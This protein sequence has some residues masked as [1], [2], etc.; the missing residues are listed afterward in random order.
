MVAVSH[1]PTDDLPVEKVNPFQP[2]DPTFGS[3]SAAPRQVPTRPAT[4]SAVCAF[5]VMVGVS[6]VL[7]Q[8]HVMQIITG[9]QAAD[10]SFLEGVL[11]VIAANLAVIGSV[12]ILV[13]R[14]T[15]RSAAALHKFED[16]RQQ[17]EA[18]AREAAAFVHSEKHSRGRPNRP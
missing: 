4:F 3:A 6:W 16:Q 18:S 10:Q 17:L 9:Q 1:N 12:W 8:H 11:M 13:R 2:G 15:R 14:Q 5:I 7:F